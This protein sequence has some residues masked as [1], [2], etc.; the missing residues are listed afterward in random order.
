M[1]VRSY[2]APPCPLLPTPHSSAAQTRHAGIVHREGSRQRG[3]DHPGCCPSVHNAVQASRCGRGHIPTH[4]TNHTVAVAAAGSCSSSGSHHHHHSSRAVAPA[5][6]LVLE[7]SAQVIA[8]QQQTKHMQRD[9]HATHSCITTPALVLE[10]PSFTGRP[11]RCS[12]AGNQ[13]PTSQPASIHAVW[14]G[15][16]GART[17]MH[18]AGGSTSGSPADTRHRGRLIRLLLLLL[19]LGGPLLGPRPAVWEALEGGAG[20]GGSWV[21]ALA[22][23]QLLPR[24]CSSHQGALRVWSHAGA[25]INPA[26]P[27]ASQPNQDSVGRECRTRDSSGAFDAGCTG[28]WRV[29]AGPEAEAEAEPKRQTEMLTTC[30]K[31]AST[32]LTWHIRKERRSLYSHGDW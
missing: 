20:G 10:L 3:G 30:C 1:P 19:L 28:C 5:C 2:G 21:E 14:S 22:D 15:R 29:E 17:A 32:G 26:Q 4:A 31:G 25:P 9:Q 16:W 12:A 27:R 11:V 13:M 6:T 23:A 18:A 24:A 8:T 7:Q